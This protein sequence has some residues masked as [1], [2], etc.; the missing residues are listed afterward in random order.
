M[1]RVASITVDWYPDEA[2][3]R[4]A[5]RRAIAVENPEC[6]RL[7]PLKGESLRRA[8]REFGITPPDDLEWLSTAQAAALLNV[9]ESAVFDVSSD[10]NIRRMCDFTRRTKREQLRYNAD[11]VRALAAQS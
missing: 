6:N 3:A 2:T 5:E 4:Q 8:Q 1:G 11:D 10:T 7:R 9:P